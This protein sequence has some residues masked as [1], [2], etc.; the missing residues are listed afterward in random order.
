MMLRLRLRAISVSAVAAVAFVLTG[1]AHAQAPA[2]TCDYMTGSG[3][4]NTTANQTHPLAKASFVMSAGCKDGSPTWGNLD[5]RDS[6]NGLH[7]IW[8]SMTGYIWAGN[9]GTDSKTGQPHGTRIIC[10]TATT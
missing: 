10:G 5:Y 9:D 1:I 6:S 3:W 4:F 7:A 8:T 2:G